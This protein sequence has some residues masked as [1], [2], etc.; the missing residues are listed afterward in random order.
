MSGDAHCMRLIH[1]DGEKVYAVRTAHSM[2][3]WSARVS[4]TT[5]I[6]SSSLSSNTVPQSKS[7]NVFNA[8]AD[9]LHQRLGHLH[10]AA[11]RRFC[12][13]HHLSKT[14]TL[15]ILAKSHRKPF[16]SKLPQSSRILFRV[17]TDVFWSDTIS[18]MFGQEVFFNL[19]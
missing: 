8:S 15:C 4:P 13:S 2:E 11:L 16:S 6:L 12:S 3:L 18:Y 7:I 5:P 19:H 17:H 14:C 10:S 9:I 1:P